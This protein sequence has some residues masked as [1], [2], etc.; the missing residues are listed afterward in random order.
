MPAYSLVNT[1]F[2]FSI[3]FSS[4]NGLEIDFSKI[5]IEHIRQ[6]LLAGASCV[7]I[8]EKFLERIE[9]YEKGPL[10]LNALVVI[11]PKASEE[12]S[13]L[14]KHFQRTKSF[15]GTLHCVP[16][17]V[18][19]NIDVAHLPTTVG[20]RGEYVKFDEETNKNSRSLGNVDYVLFFWR[21]IQTRHF[22]G[23]FKFAMLAKNPNLRLLNLSLKS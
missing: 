18:G 14:D 10:Q 20:V 16:M 13:E 3:L 8:I 6:A 4:T 1:F 15:T 2:W 17:V 23:K 7:E 22:S 5:N 11:N 9:K 21:E 19:D 12:A